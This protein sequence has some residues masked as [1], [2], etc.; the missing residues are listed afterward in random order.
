[1]TLEEA[2][3]LK[4][5]ALALFMVGNMTLTGCTSSSAFAFKTGKDNV[6][7]A[8]EGSYVNSQC[9]RDCVVAEVYNELLDEKQL[10]IVK[11]M[12][13]SDREIYYVDLL[14]PTGPVFYQVND[15]NNFIKFIKSTPVLDFIE[16]L[17]IGKM[18]YSHEDMV[19]ILEQIKDVYEYTDLD[20]LTLG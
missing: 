9:L 8:Y 2:R 4:A 14:S 3:R 5:G 20:V 1:M 16:A 12:E 15:K 17:G 13:N 19:A 18:R 11:E 10:Y 7:V 6:A